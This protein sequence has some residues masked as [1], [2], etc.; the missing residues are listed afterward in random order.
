M[1]FNYLRSS[2]NLGESFLVVFSRLLRSLFRPVLDY[3][4]TLQNFLRRFQVGF[5]SELA[6]NFLCVHPKYPSIRQFW[7]KF[8]LKHYLKVFS[9][10][11]WQH[12]ERAFSRMFS[13]REISSFPLCDGILRDSASLPARKRPS[14]L[15]LMFTIFEQRNQKELRHL[16]VN[17]AALMCFERKG[18]SLILL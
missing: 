8:L 17:V 14:N 15:T 10:S 7:N 9:R 1:G 4:F 5:R 18:K 6:W 16:N 11:P 12:P 13:S 3:P 2:E